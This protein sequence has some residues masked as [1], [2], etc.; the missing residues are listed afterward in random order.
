MKTRFLKNSTF[1]LVAVLFLMVG[2]VA[3]RPLLIEIPRQSKNE[4]PVDVQSLLLVSRVVDGRF[5]DLKTD[6][7]QRIFYKKNF[8]Y[9]TIVR[10]VQSVDT[11][12]KAL[13]DLLFE[14]GR[15]DIVIPEKRF[16][17]FE[18]N[19][20]LSREMPWQEVADLCELYDTDAL[21]S[22]DHFVTRVS[23]DFDKES[24]FDPVQN[25]FFAAAEA[26]MTIT[27]EALIRVYDPV[28]EKVL[29]RE[30]LRDTLFWQDGD[31]STGEL[32]NRFTP[33]KTALSEAGI[34]VA[35]DFSA[36]IS[37]VWEPARRTVF[38]KGDKELK[39][40]ASFVSA[41]EW[42][43][44]MAIWKELV[45]KANSKALK[46]KAEYNIAVGYELQ[47]DLESA[48]I[49]ALQSYETMYRNITY[50]YLEKLKRRKNDLKK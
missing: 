22:L 5:T 32:F 39:K 1:S 3:T 34:A 8:S 40:A 50:D 13:G 31:V 47:G 24:Y 44:A 42:E 27:Y 29:A 17:D 25:S 14:S 30:F 26:Q 11:T 35:L 23:T 19:A 16:L 2:C 48:I 45:L 18:T 36:K 28:R 12:L 41:N 21:L 38:V 43:A 20:F 15:Y 9:D 10:D 37:T 7:L 49:W 33:V 46:S 4:L 6:S